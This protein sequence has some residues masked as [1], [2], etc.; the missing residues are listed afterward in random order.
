MVFEP[1]DREKILGEYK[2]RVAWYQGRLR[3]GTQLKEQWYL[4]TP[5]YKGV[6]D[7]TRLFKRPEGAYAVKGIGAA[8]KTIQTLTGEVPKF[9]LGM[10]FGF[11]DLS[12]STPARTGDKSALVFKKDLNK[13]TK[14][15]FN[16]TQIKTV[17]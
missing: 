3:Q 7:V 11:L 1:Y 15:P 17:R 6:E 10:D 8:F 12:V 9:L 14:M 2:G 4:I 16:V 13:M 5:P